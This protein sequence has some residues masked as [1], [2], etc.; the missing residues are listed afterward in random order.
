MVLRLAKPALVCSKLY[1]FSI[2]IHIIIIMSLR[3][4]NQHDDYS[5]QNSC[6]FFISV[7]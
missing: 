6:R 1:D 3:E 5:I 7:D 2:D 4:L